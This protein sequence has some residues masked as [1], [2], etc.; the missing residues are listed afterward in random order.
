MLYPEIQPYASG[1]LDVGQGHRIYW[2]QCGNPEGQPI[3]FL[4]G[5]PGGGCTPQSRRFFDP[6]QYRVLLFDQRGCGRSTPHAGTQHN[7][8]EQLVNDMELLR[9]TLQI[10][11]WMLYGGSWG[12]A[13]ALAYTKLHRQR[14]RALVLRSVF[15]GQRHE[16]DWLYRPGGASQ[17]LAQDWQAFATALGP[18]APTDLLAG[19]AECLRGA[20]AARQQH[21]ALAWCRWENALQSLHANSPTEAPEPLHA[22]AMA[23]ISTHYFV[24]DP[25]LAHANFLWPAYYL[26]GLPG[27]IVQGQHDMV[28]PSATAWQLHQAW[29]GSELRMVPEAGHASSNL[30]LRKAVLGA[31]DDILITT[32]RPVWQ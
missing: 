13:L 32:R 30:A 25:W 9:E 4:H 8:C 21:A 15:T 27:I 11:Q 29:P 1:L 22:L 6:R 16:L 24:N 28:T 23:R 31:L 3:V 26:A 5:G 19:Y 12:C 14:V 7:G 17:V 2:E 10:D 18:L 20:D